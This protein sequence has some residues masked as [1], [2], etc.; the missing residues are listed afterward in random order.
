MAAARIVRHG[1]GWLNTDTGR[2]LAAIAGA[3]DPPQDPPSDPPSGDPPSDPPQDPPHQDPPQDP[4]DP[5][6]EPSVLRAEVQRLRREAAEREKER[7]KAE[8]EAARAEEQRKADQGEWRKLAEERAGRITELEGQLVERDRRDAEREQ[9]TT[10]E[11]VAERLLFRRP[12]RAWALLID[13]LGPEDAASTLEDEQLTEAA[14]RR[15]AKDMPELVDQQRR[16]GAPV[17]GRNGGG[18]KPEEE[19]ADLVFGLLG[20]RPNP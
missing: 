1:D 6:D 19:H 15:L 3:E 2:W 12:K 5:K 8:R 13:E 16:S 20:L 7:R 9:R 14:L 4:P 10:V 18:S 11:R 17:G